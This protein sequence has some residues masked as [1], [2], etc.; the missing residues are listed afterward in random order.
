MS[1]DDRRRNR[2][3]ALGGDRDVS[4][5]VCSAE[6]Y[7]NAGWIP[8]SGRPRRLRPHGWVYLRHH[9]RLVARVRAV[10]TARLAARPRRTPRPDDDGFGPGPVVLVDPTTFEDVHSDLG[11]LASRQRSGVRYLRATRDRTVVHL[12]ASEALPAGDWD[13]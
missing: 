8:V 2:S 6:A 5:P 4:V 13:A 7:R 1:I 3:G 12:A 9:G 10:G 11:P